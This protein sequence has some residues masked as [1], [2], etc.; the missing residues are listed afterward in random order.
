M[1]AGLC[2]YQRNEQVFENTKTSNFT[3]FEY[4]E[5]RPVGYVLFLESGFNLIMIPKRWLNFKTVNNAIRRHKPPLLPDVPKQG[6]VMARVEKAHDL[7]QNVNDFQQA[8]L[9]QNKGVIAKGEGLWLRISLKSTDLK[10]SR[11]IF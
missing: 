6:G 2:V 4:I 9:L 8:K 10:N 5:A 3:V 7:V 11:Q 1:L